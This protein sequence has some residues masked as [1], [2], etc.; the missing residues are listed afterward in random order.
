[1][2]T[3]ISSGLVG[4]IGPYADFT[5]LPFTFWTTKG[6]GGKLNYKL[7]GVEKN[8]DPLSGLPSGPVNFFCEKKITL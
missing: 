8:L 5:F 1:M 6:Q 3:G 2:E 4:H 7:M